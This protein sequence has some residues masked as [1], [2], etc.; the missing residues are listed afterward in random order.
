MSRKSR[1][2]LYTGDGKG[3]TTAAMGMALRSAGY[4]M[5][6]LV[7]Q[8]V[9]KCQTGEKESLERLGSV[10]F[11]QTGLGFVPKP[12]SE[13]FDQHKQAAK[14]GLDILSQEI[15]ENRYNLIILDEI[16]VAVDLKLL[17]ESGVLNVLRKCPEDTA[18]VLTGRNA[19]KGLINFADTVSEVKCIKHG[20]DDGFKAQKGLEF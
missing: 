2:L 12:D 9:K 19:S 3:K 4:A 13:K 16:C 18:L 17:D 10:K 7:I 20:F 1:V 5:D 14:R 8:F 15:D 6:V 11:I